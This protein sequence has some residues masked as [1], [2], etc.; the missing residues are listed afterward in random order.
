[1]NRKKTLFLAQ[2]GIIGAL[3]AA[4]TVTQQLIFPGSAS[5]SV[6]FRV[7]EVLTLLCVFIPSAI[8]G[9]TV[10]C[11]IANLTSSGA[12]PIDTVLGATATLLAG[13]V[14]YKL[15]NVR[16]KGFP[17]LSALMP[18]I[19]NGI[20]IGWELE[21]FYIDGPFNFT[22]FLIQCGLVA[23]GEVTVCLVLGVPFVKVFEKRLM[24][25]IN[26]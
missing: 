15:R 11:L 8:P 20:I 18:A 2:A 16:V 19:F 26:R 10:G 12:L 3:Y 13:L 24:K 17:L 23:L 22:S 4:L 6:Q 1:M 7:A 25:I 9:V 5:L 14:M 21:V